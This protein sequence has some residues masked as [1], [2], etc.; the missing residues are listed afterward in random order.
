MSDSDIPAADITPGCPH[1]RLATTL[2]GQ[3]AAEAAFLDSWRAGRLHHAWL[4]TG[5]RR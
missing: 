3:Q 1:P 4:L 2:Y 5:A